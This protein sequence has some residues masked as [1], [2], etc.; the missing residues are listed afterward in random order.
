M[1]NKTQNHLEKVGDKLEKNSGMS[2]K[3]GL[4]SNYG[5]CQTQVKYFTA[6]AVSL[7]TKNIILMALTM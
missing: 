7:E 5:Q 2:R 3:S 1:F 6:M 4:C